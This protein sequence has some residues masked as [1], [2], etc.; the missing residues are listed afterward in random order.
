MPDLLAEAR[1][2]RKEARAPKALGY[3]AASPALAQLPPIPP[4]LASLP[5]SVTY[6]PDFVCEADEELLLSHVRQAPQSRWSGSEGDGRRTQN[7]GGAPGSLQIAEGLPEWL[8]PLVKAVVE[9]GVWGDTPPPNHVLVNVFQPGSG[10]VPHTDGPLY[11]G[12]RVATLSLGSDVFLDLHEP[13]VAA[14]HAS[15]LLRRRSLNVISAEAYHQ[16]HG[17]AERASDVVNGTVANAEAAGATPGECV[18]RAPRVSIVFVSK[19]EEGAAAASPLALLE[20]VAPPGG[21]AG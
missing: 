16:F 9:S 1:R 13:H 17:I 3:A 19:L 15:L 14:P 12:P 11:A 4:P 2:R 21:A 7:Y 10:L 20:V 5:P 8:A 6:V 18:P